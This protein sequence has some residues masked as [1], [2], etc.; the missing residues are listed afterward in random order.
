LKHQEIAVELATKNSCQ[1]TARNKS[2]NKTVCLPTQTAGT[3]FRL[4]YDPPNPRLPG[5]AVL[6][7]IEMNKL[8]RIEKVTI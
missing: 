7:P 2:A 1:Q 5:Q 4:P 6:T 3:G 8:E